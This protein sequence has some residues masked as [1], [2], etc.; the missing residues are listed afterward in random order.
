MEAE[1][2]YDDLIE[3]FYKF[4]R[5]NNSWKLLIIGGGSLKGQLERKIQ[6]KRLGDKVTITGYVHNVRELLLRGQFSL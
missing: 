1:K 4:N 6:E 2:E 5:C 3:A